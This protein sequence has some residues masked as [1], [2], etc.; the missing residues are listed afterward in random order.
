[1]NEWIKPKQSQ[2]KWEKN[3]QIRMGKGKVVATF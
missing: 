3:I 1:M 2:C